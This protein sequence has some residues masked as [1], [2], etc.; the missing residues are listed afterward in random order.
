T[1]TLTRA[2]LRQRIEKLP[3]IRLGHLPTPLEELPRL[4]EA[5]GGPRIF[6]KRDDATGMAFGGNKVR[7]YEFEMAH[8]RDLGY[9]ALVNIM[10]Y[11]SNN[12]RLT[13]AAANRMGFKYVL[14]LKNSRGRPVQGNRLVD[15]LP[16]A[17]VHDL[18]PVESKHATE[19]ARKIGQRLEKEGHRPY[20]LQEHE[21]PKIAGSIAYVDAGLELAQQLEERNITRNIHIVGVAGRSTAGLVLA[22]KNLGLGWKVTGVTVTYDITMKDYLYDVVAGAVR[23]LDLPIGFDPGDMEILTDYVG[24][25][26]GIMTQ[27]VGEV[28]HLFAQKEAIF[29][30][31]NYTGTVAAALVDQIRR[32]R[33]PKDENV[34]FLHTGGLPAIF[35]FSGE[36]A[37]WRD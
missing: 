14:I 35:T 1:R 6:I 27:E 21:F 3:R 30:D 32:G 12:A 23:E 33:I 20:L 4:S 29:V 28:I 16:G 18:G 19:Y 36:L 9:N 13:G 37:A 7:H 10:D 22:S 31:P 2:E 34:V 24:E 8:V 26:Y 25:G 11:H 17:E 15:K 5:L